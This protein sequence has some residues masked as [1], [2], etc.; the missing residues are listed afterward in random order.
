ML[1]NTLVI[2]HSGL[3]RFQRPTILALCLRAVGGM[4]KLILK[5]SALSLIFCI[6]IVAW[7]VIV[8]SD[9]IEEAKIHMV[10][11]DLSLLELAIEEYHS[12]KGNY[13][14]F[15]KDLKGSYLN[16]IPVDPNLVPYKYT[17]QN[18]GSSYQLKQSLS[19]DE[20]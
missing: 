7:Y 3:G 13:P 15:L 6:S 8:H 11:S 14:E 17:K 12:D 20:G 1:N 16:V 18:D 19:I 9:S 5:L 10:K 4:N 2:A